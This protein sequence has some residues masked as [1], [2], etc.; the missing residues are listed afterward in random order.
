[1]FIDGKTHV[2]VCN[3]NPTR[4]AVIATGITI[5]IQT[6]IA[7]ISMHRQNVI[8]FHP[9]NSDWSRATTLLQIEQ[10][11][12]FDKIKGHNSVTNW[13]KMTDCNPNLELVKINTKTKFGKIWSFFPFY[14]LSANQFWHQSRA[15]TVLQICEKWSTTI[16]TILDLVN[17]N[18]YTKIG[19]TL[20]IGPMWNPAI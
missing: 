7:S 18:A 12:N 1:M 17:I 16:S 14:I 2:L 9:W 8:E 4:L 15:I 13:Q 3:L 11:Q 5:P 6:Y 20:I 10:R 19:K